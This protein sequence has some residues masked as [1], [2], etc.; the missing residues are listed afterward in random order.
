MRGGLVAAIDKE[1]HFFL[2]RHAAT[3]WNR[4]GRIQGQ[5]DSPLSPAGERQVGDWCAHVANLGLG[6]ICSSDLGR[7][8]ATA[9]GLNR[10][11]HLPFWTEPRLRELDWG[12]WT[13]RIHR[14]LRHEDPD[15]YARESGRG[16]QFR[17]PG[18]ES[19][20]DVLERAL[21]A[22][23]DI[24]TRPGPERILI[25]THEGVLKCLVYHL[26]I[27]DGCGQPPETMAP[28]HLHH[29][30]SRGHGLVLRKMNAVNLN[31]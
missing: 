8:V 13:G 31:L 23:N 15:R 27:R 21:A 14:R 29:L 22:L 6:A 5:A 24:G 9:R 4:E 20:I 2:M 12:R 30:V 7:A 3:V 18:G 26:A 25:V 17:P 11:G 1:H 10:E 19:H 28:G 16:W